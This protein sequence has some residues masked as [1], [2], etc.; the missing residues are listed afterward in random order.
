MRIGC[1]KEKD[2]WE[3][4]IVARM[5]LMEARTISRISNNFPWKQSLVCASASKSNVIILIIILGTHAQRDRDRDTET[6][7]GLDWFG[8]VVVEFV[9]S[10]LNRRWWLKVCVMV[11]KTG[12][13]SLSCVFWFVKWNLGVLVAIESSM[14]L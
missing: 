3:N 10:G 6:E 7:F 8:L 2:T 1:A 12:K 14:H 9:V 5:P 13:Q 11:D 4:A